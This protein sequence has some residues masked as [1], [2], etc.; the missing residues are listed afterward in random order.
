MG[1]RTWALTPRGPP[2]ETSA[3]RLWGH[4]RRRRE[5]FSQARVPPTPAQMLP[6]SACHTGPAV[7]ARKADAGCAHSGPPLAQTPACLGR[8]LILQTSLSFPYLSAPRAMHRCGSLSLRWATQGQV[9]QPGPHSPGLS[10]RTVHGQRVGR[11]SPR[12][13]PRLLEL[14]QV[15][16]GPTATALPAQPR[17]PPHL[18]IDS[19]RPGPEQTHSPRGWRQ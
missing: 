19:I 1:S 13:P 15:P 3:P 10:D 9:G 11:K 12:A 7:S 4:C 18:A 8:G 2:S 14:G 17:A 5:R 6:R 16:G